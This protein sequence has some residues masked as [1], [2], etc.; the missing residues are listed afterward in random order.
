MMIQGINA[1]QFSTQK[2]GMLKNQLAVQNAKPAVN[3]S[4]VGWTNAASDAIKTH[5]FNFRFSPKIILT[6]Y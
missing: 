5:N 1:T 6:P 4:Y 2:L 3:N